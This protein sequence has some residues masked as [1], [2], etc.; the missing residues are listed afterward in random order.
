MTESDPPYSDL[1]D[2]HRDPAP[3]SVEIPAQLGFKQVTPVRTIAPQIRT[4]WRVSALISGVILALIAG[5]ITF[6]IVHDHS[7]LGFKLLITL[8]VAVVGFLLGGIGLFTADI[9]WK[10]WTYQLREHD[11]VMGYGWF[12]QHKRFVARDRIQHVDVN[13]GPLDRRFGL[14]Q[15]V[16]YAAGAHS[17]IGTIPGLSPEEAEFLRSQLLLSRAEHA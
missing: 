16:V 5:G 2:V 9:Q 11:L 8:G 10:S 1:P 12:W 6:L 13:S 7:S 3:T 14:V 17:T 15:V 4:V